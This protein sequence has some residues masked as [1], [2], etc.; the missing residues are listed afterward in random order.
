MLYLDHA[1]VKAALLD[2]LRT[3]PPRG[4]LVHLLTVRLQASMG[5]VRPLLNRWLAD[6]A[7]LTRSA[8]VEGLRLANIARDPNLLGPLAKM[9][10]DASPLVRHAATNAI[11]AYADAAALEALR[12]VVRDPDGWVREQAINAVGWVAQAAPRGSAL[13]EEAIALLRTLRG[14]STHPHN[15]AVHWL[16]QLGAE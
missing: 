5:E 12:K 16:Q 13:R 4:R 8:A 9:L 1:M 6:P 2:S 11:G 7:D 10:G 15:S 14:L 3:E